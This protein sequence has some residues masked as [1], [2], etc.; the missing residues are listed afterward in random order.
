MW[1]FEGE[2]P[3]ISVDT[4]ISSHIYVF[5]SHMLFTYIL[6][7][8]RKMRVEGEVCLRQMAPLPHAQSSALNHLHGEAL[9][10]TM[11]NV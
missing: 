11:D 2:V 7:C 9:T 10:Y 1:P 6:Y 3:N 4:C 8:L 5:T